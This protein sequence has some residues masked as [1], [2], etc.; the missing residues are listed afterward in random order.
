MARPSTEH[1]DLSE[2][3]KRDLIKFNP[4]TPLVV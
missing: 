1:Y 2:T 3:E 4:S